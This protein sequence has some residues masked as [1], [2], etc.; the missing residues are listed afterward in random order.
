MTPLYYESH[1]TIEPV[2]ETTLEIFKHLCEKHGFKAA[3]L[4][5][6]KERESVPERSNKD[7]FATGQDEKFIVLQSRMHSLLGDLMMDGFK[8]WRYKIE[9]ILLDQK[10]DRDEGYVVTSLDGVTWDKK[11]EQFEA[12]KNPH[13]G[14][15]FGDIPIK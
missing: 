11:E 4:L 2:F 8:V 3:N 9:A 7:T 10:L 13:E 14:E 5:M 12:T 6:Q 15:M 1:I